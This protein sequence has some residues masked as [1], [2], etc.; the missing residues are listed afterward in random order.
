MLLSSL[1]LCVIVVFLSTLQVNAQK[2]YLNSKLPASERVELLLKEMTLDEKI[3]Q[4]C[5]FVG[6]ASNN[7]V[8][9]KDEEVNY[10]L[11]LGERARLI[12][13]GK[14]GSFLKVPTYKEANY[15]QGLA[16][17]SR[18]KIPLLIAN[19][20]IH[21]HGMYKGPTTV[22]PTQIGLA[23]SFDT[24]LANKVARYTAFE[25]RATGNHWAFSPNIEVVRDARWGRNGETFGEDPLLVSAMGT[26]MIKGYQGI[27]FAGAGN[28][29]ACAK[30]FVGGGIAVNGLNGAPAD[31]SE[32]TLHEIF[33][34]PFIEAIKAG[35]YTIMPAH[36]EINGI[37]C[38]AHA[39][40]LTGLIRNKWGFN[41]IFVSD[42]N[43]IEK[44]YSVHH[45]AASEKD[46][47]R[48]AVNAGLDVHMHGPNF[49]DNVKQLVQE[50][51]IPLE[52]VDDAV[53]KILFAKFQLGLFENRYVDSLR[54][55]NTLLS[56]EHTGLALEGARKSMVLLKNKNNLLPLGKQIKSVFITGPGA[57]NQSLL[58]DWSGLQPDDNIITVYEGIRKVAPANT[59]IDYEPWEHYDSI[60]NTILATVQEK[61][62]KADVAIVVVGENSIRFDKNKT[63]GENLD[64]AT[65]ELAGTQNEFLK[66]VCEAG[67]PVIVVLINGGPVASPWMADRADAILEAWEPGMFGG[68]AVAEVLFGEYNPGGRLPITFPQ[69]VGHLQSFYNHKPSSFHRGR[70]Y[71]SKREP[72][73]GF[74]HGLSYTR[75]QYINLNMPSKIG[76][77]DSL[78]IS[79]T[80][81]NAGAVKGDEVVLVYLHDKLSS[82]TTPV[83]KLVAFSRIGLNPKERKDLKFVIPNSAFKL[84]DQ[85]MNLVV[86]PGQFEILVGNNNLRSEVTVE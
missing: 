18:L 50:G 55:K 28:V 20:A 70:F 52:R 3:G 31:V 66:A 2:S 68:Q 78:V 71:N 23:S 65:L 15:L 30:H 53:R 33:F 77:K 76:L 69:T 84:F 6:E 1:R 34:P 25:M 24:S 14:I 74:G 42:W 49:F 41:G 75:F 81:E 80:L 79:F 46:A 59:R 12:K 54:V 38:H 67:K 47:D 16:E 32:R 9:N 35:A 17:Q 58:G 36:N 26:A 56:K 73:F 29:L 40:Y 64:R 21:G 63:S 4:M 72:L 7:V 45:I 37:P 61:A 60:N 13:E 82:V 27:D 85:N 86:E 48:L 51:T 57:N 83:K 44:L 39:P 22:F 62:S 19:D 11:G 43:D 10:V 5:Q 8:A